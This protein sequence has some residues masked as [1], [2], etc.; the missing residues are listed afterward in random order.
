MILHEVSLALLRNHLDSTLSVL[1]S[2]GDRRKC[3]HSDGMEMISFV[4]RLQYP[5][6]I[7]VFKVKNILGRDKN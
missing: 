6:D 4:P 2:A 5:T 3:N 7:T 1:L